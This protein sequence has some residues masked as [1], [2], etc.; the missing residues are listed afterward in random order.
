VLADASA[1][2]EKRGEHLYTIGFASADLWPEAKGR[3]DR[4]FVDLWESYLEPA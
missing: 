3:D 1:R 2:G 4:V